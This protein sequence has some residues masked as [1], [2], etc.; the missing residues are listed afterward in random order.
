MPN[1]NQLTFP[2]QAVAYGISVPEMLN[3]VAAALAGWVIGPFFIIPLVAVIGRSAVI[4]Y[5]LLGI[6]A[7]QM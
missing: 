2:V 6:F 5:S 1:A 3:S 7:C 4:F